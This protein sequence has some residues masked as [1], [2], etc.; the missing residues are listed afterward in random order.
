MPILPISYSYGLVAVSVL[1]S[2][3]AAYAAFGLS[4]RMRLAKTPASRHGWL[5]G[6]STAVGIGT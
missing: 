2:I 4:D 5:A 1:L 6:G 3:I